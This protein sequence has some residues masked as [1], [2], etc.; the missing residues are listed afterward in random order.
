MAVQAVLEAVVDDQNEQLFTD[1]ESYSDELEFVDVNASNRCSDS[2]SGTQSTTLTTTTDHDAAST[3]NNCLSNNLLSRL[4]RPTAAEISGKRV[5]ARNPPKGR[6]RAR[7]PHSSDPK[8][9]T[10]QQRLKKYPNECLTVSHGKLFCLACREELSTKSSVIVNHIKSVK[11]NSGKNALKSKQNKDLE[12]V[13]ALKSYEGSENPHGEMPPDQQ[14][15]YRVK[16]L[17]TFL[18]AGVPLNKLSIFREL[19]EE[20]GYRLTDR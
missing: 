3:S 12:L 6:K 10:P 13:E 9:V 20:N 14:R 4:C 18:T 17:R 8:S 11:H 5:V 7:G 1:S 16:V 2:G 19:L 15:L